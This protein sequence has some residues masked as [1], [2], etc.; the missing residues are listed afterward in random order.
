MYPEL[1]IYLTI[2]SCSNSKI[3]RWSANKKSIIDLHK[4]NNAPFQNIEQEWMKLL[5]KQYNIHETNDFLYQMY[6]IYR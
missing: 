5:I 2:V 4:S 1:L 3:A 6:Y